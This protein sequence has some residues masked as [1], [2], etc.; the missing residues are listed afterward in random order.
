MSTG[1]ASKAMQSRAFDHLKVDLSPTRS[2]KT[3]FATMA[4]PSGLSDGD[5]EVN[6][7]ADLLRRFPDQG[8]QHMAV[9]SLA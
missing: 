1:T 7:L 3:P 6:K 4:F 2:P 9:N 8:R 5:A